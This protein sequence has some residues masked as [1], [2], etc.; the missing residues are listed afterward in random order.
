MKFTKKNV[1]LLLGCVV[2]SAVLSMTGAVKAIAAEK[3]I[4]VSE[5]LYVCGTIHNENGQLTLRNI[6]GETAMDEIVL[7]ISEET[8]ILDA[9]NG[10]PV[11]VDNLKDGESVY[12]YISQA[13]TLSL[14][15]QSYASM[16]ICRIPADFAA[17]AYE[18]VD[19]LTQ[20]ADGTML[21]TT[22]RQNQYTID[23]A[24]SFLPFLTRNIATV[25]DLT[26]GRTCLVWRTPT[27]AGQTG[28]TNTASKIVVFAPE[29]SSGNGAASGPASDP[30]LIGK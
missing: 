30:E 4:P 17:P 12:A 8:R 14:P 16:I 2:C 24:T 3:V 25:Q 21:L 15:P 5:P 20:N 29:N 13:M 7:N 22:M 9:V 23:A 19:T 10:F 18:K 1:S 27:T 6:Q 28:N 26:K 11:S